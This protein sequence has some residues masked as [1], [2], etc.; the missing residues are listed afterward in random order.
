MINASTV[1]VIYGAAIHVLAMVG[2]IVLT[3]LN[4]SLAPTTVPVI[5]TLGGLGVGAG[6]ALITP[7]ATSKPSDAQAP[8]TGATGAAPA[9]APIQ[10]P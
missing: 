4:T 3:A 7:G 1:A 8:P 10:T 2:L 6:I 5:T 9:P